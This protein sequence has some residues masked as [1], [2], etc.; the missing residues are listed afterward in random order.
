MSYI[1]KLK[2]KGVIYDLKDA[3]TATQINERLQ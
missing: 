1:D 3:S 2:V